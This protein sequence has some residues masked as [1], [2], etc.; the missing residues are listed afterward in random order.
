MG[1]DL[2]VLATGQLTLRALGSVIF[3]NGVSVEDGAKVTVE[4]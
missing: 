1:P 2:N 4:E 3:V